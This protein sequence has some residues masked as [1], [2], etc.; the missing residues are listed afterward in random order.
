MTMKH[1]FGVGLTM[2]VVLIVYFVVVDQFVM[3]LGGNAVAGK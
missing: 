2:L 1:Y 3:G